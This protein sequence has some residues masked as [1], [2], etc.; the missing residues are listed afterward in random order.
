MKSYTSSIQKCTKAADFIGSY[1]DFTTAYGKMRT[2]SL[3]WVT[4]ETYKS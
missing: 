3:A 4:P 1:L 2:I